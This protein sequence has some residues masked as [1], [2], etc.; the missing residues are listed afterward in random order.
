MRLV[1]RLRIDVNLANM[2]IVTIEQGEILG[3]DKNLNLS[4]HQD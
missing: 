2:K 4:R 1:I 3:E